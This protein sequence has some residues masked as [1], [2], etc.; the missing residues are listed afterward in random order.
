VNGVPLPPQHGFPIRLLVPGWYGMTSV[1]WLRKITAVAEPF[2]GFQ[3]WAYAIRDD[4]DEPGT[5]VTRIEPRALM[6]PPGFP[7]FFSRARVLD[8]GPCTLEGR[9]W[10][11]RAAIERVEVSAD[12][13][14]TWADATLA[15]L[16]APYAWRAWHHGW[17]AAPGEHELVVRATDGTGETQPLEQPWNHHGLANN[18][19]QRVPVTVRAPA[20]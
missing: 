1:K 4:E 5:P 10:S 12:G 6:V 15:P 20:H 3:Q 2:T 7:E 11:G 16:P 19:V 8:A 9:A 13:G 17:D 14:D 18:M